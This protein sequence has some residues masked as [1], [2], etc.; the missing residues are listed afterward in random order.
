MTNKREEVFQTIIERATANNLLL[1]MSEDALKIT[2]LSDPEAAAFLGVGHSTLAHKRSEQCTLPQDQRDEKSVG[3]IPHI[4]NAAVEYRL[5][6]LL[7]YKLDEEPV[8][9]AIKPRSEQSKEKASATHKANAAKNAKKEQER[10]AGALNSTHRA[11]GTFM[12]TATGSDTWPFSIQSDGRPLDL[13]SAIL[14]GTLTGKA[15]R[16]NLREFSARLANVADA[17]HSSQ[18]N[19]VLRD[20]TPEANEPEGDRRDRWTK[21]GGAM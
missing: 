16:L 5:Y 14:D 2:R 18:E 17:E 15:E 13:Y 10:A 19:Q 11:F 8:A 1:A 20:E 6:D 9:C 21:N 12:Q 4:P 3:A 7:Q